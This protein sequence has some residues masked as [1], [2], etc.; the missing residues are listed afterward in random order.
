MSLLLGIE[1]SRS[2][3]VLTVVDRS[4]D[5]IN[6]I[7]EQI[8]EPVANWW[9]CHPDEWL[10]GVLAAL[11]RAVGEGLIA[12]EKVAAIGLSA[13]PGLVLLDADL[14]PLPPRDLSWEE[15]LGTDM[16]SS[17]YSALRAL[18]RERPRTAAR[19][20]VILGPLDYLRF[21]MTGSLATHV[22]FAWGTGLTVGA[23]HV[24]SWDR[25]AI[26]E[27]GYP[28]SA[29]PLH[30]ASIVSVVS[31]PCQAGETNEPGR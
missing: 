29:L 5:V 31:F 13:E 15:I 23:E 1:L 9:R 12:G 19:V 4:S 24:T 14:K 10:R 6:S 16:E 22:G 11:E 30:A 7:T 3:V 21:R 2:Q 25:A 27:L 26:Q 17:P 8:S 18:A 28:P 20:G